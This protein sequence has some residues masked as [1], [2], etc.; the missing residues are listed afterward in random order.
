MRPLTAG[1]YRDI[2]G[3]I[4]INHKKVPAMPLTDTSCKNAKPSE[5]ARKLSDSAGL[6]LEVMPNGSKY[7][8]LK[9]RFAGKEKRLALG[10][11]PAVGL[12]EARDKRDAARKLLSN[13][14]DPSQAK[15]EEKHQVLLRQENSFETIAREWYGRR[16]ISANLRVG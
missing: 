9:Y 15:K 14:I 11:Y 4:R 6:Y 1:A 7:W 12:K 10:V 13:N 5:K 3:G 8:R 2:F 16:N